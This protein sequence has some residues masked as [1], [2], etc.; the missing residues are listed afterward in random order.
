M[1]WKKFNLYNKLRCMLKTT[2]RE[3]RKNAVFKRGT[4]PTINTVRFT[5]GKTDAEGTFSSDRIDSACDI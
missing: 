2:Y 4:F 5:I 1:Q 3:R